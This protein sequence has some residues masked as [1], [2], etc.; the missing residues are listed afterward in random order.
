MYRRRAV[1][2]DDQYK[3]NVHIHEEN[4]YNSIT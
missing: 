1:D 2:I 3:D 4:A